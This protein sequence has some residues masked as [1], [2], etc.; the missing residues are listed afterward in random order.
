MSDRKMTIAI[1]LP[2]A[3]RSS[4]NLNFVYEKLHAKNYQQMEE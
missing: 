1:D 4:Y 3:F 2:V